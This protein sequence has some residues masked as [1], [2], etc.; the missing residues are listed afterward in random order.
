MRSGFPQSGALGLATLALVACGE[1]GGGGKHSTPAHTVAPAR[2]AWT[3]Y[4]YYVRFNGD[5]RDRDVMRVPLT[6][7]RTNWAT[8]S[9][10]RRVVQSTMAI[11]PAQA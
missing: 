4:L 6:L 2:Y 5:D 9:F 8:R 11:R 7:T 3:P 1:G 10:S